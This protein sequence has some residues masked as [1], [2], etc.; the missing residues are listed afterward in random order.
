M[1]EVATVITNGNYCMM[2]QLNDVIKPYKK[3]LAL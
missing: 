1:C 2:Q 3:Q